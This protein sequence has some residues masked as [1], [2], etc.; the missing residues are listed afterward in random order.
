MKIFARIRCFDADPALSSVL[1]D[2]SRKTFLYSW[3]CLVY[4]GPG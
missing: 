2:R 1:P 3:S 4:E